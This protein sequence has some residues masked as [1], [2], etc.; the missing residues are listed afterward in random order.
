MLKLIGTMLVENAQ[1]YDKCIEI[2]KQGPPTKAD[3]IRKMSD[4]E[5]AEWILNLCRFEDRDEEPMISI[6]NLDTKN[7]EEIHDSY[8]DLLEWLQRS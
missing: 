6:Y 1:E 7:T 4:E 5:L 3:R 2:A 8:G